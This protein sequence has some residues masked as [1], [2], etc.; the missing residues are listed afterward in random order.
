MGEQHACP[1]A[2]LP[3]PQG[4]N[5]PRDKDPPLSSFFFQ[6]G[7]RTLLL[8]LPTTLLAARSDLFV[9]QHFVVP[10]LMFFFPGTCGCCSSKSYCSWK[11][12][13]SSICTSSFNS[14]TCSRG[15][16]S[17][18]SFWTCTN[19]STYRW[20][21]TSGKRTSPSLLPQV[22]KQLLSTSICFV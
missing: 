14:S 22:Y 19:C 21:W 3:S 10:L 20:K 15:Y 6:K 18:S 1:R 8:L 12:S 4:Q 5:R 2:H 7:T 17:K 16:S 13:K 9:S 11:T